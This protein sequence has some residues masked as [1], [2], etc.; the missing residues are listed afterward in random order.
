M[1]GGTIENCGI[2]GGSVCYGGGVAVIYGGSFVM[3]AGEITN[4]YAKVTGIPE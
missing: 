4:C 1:L 2:D 3:D